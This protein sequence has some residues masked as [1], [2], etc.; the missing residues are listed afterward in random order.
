MIKLRAVA[1]LTVAVI[2]LPFLSLWWRGRGLSRQG[3]EAL[4]GPLW[5]SLG[6]SL[7]A[8]AAAAM[9]GLPLA[10]QLA[11]VKGIPSRIVRSILLLPVTVPPVVLGVALLS[12]F[13]R[14]GVVGRYAF[15]WFGIGLPFTTAGAVVAAFVVSLPVVTLVGEGAFRRVSPGLVEVA[16]T[17]GADGRT[18]FR[19]VVMP[20]A[21]SGVASGLALGWARAFGEFG[22]TLVFAG[23]VPG[24]TQTL[25]L[26]VVTVLEGDPRQALVLAA[27][28]ALLGLVT[29]VVVVM[30]W[31]PDR[32]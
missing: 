26:S 15:N 4:S 18:A 19:K 5:L 16:R 11:K 10:W 22:A 30:L 1:A 27:A 17:L 13:G 9:F 3:W 2:A 32:R 24:R 31:A 12:G 20:V 23:N 25:P 29:A 8:A 6:V 7:A 21:A 28:A 14:N